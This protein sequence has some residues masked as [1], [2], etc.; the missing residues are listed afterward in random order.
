DA[1]RVEVDASLRRSAGDLAAAADR[2]FETSI[3]AL[4]ALAESPALAGGDLAQFYAMAA[5]V[6]QQRHWG[7]VVLLEPDG[8]QVLNLLLPLGTGMPNVGT[9]P[10]LR[11]VIAGKRPVV[12]DLY[13]GS[14]SGDWVI[15]VAVPV[16]RGDALRQVLLAVIYASD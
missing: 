8:S 13:R 15:S 4:Q 10:Y 11:E 1:E 7:T 2:E 5:T 3:A 6:R 14:I 9:R 16:L 12:S